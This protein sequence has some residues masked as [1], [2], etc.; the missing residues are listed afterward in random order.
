MAK[1]VI[2]DDRIVDFLTT[3]A[4]IY[5]G[6]FPPGADVSHAIQ[7]YLDMIIS[8]YIVRRLGALIAREQLSTLIEEPEKLYAF[9]TNYLQ[10][11]SIE[12]EEGQPTDASWSPE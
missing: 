11:R 8:E 4:Q 5:R 3:G 9:A 12:F 7:L 1:I 2:T 10:N 6:V